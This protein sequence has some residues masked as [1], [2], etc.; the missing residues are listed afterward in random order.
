MI[1]NAD[2]LDNSMVLTSQ[3]DRGSDAFVRTWCHRP[4][5]AV[6]RRR[7]LTWGNELK[8]STDVEFFRDVPISPPRSHVSRM[9][10]HRTQE[11]HE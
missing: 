9:L 1:L 11:E 3:I 7:W 10:K 5:K 6:P 2:L 8:S 4:R